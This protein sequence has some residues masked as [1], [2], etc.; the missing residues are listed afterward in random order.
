MSIQHYLINRFLKRFD[1]TSFDVF[2][3][4]GE[5]LH[6]GPEDSKFKMIMHKPLDYKAILTSTSLALGEAYMNGDFDIEGDLYVAIDEILHLKNQFSLDSKAL[7]KILY[8]S[9]S[10]KNQKN[11]VSS[12]YDIGNDFYK[13]WLDKTLSYSCAYFINEEDSLYE[14]QLNKVHYILAKLNLEEG[15]SL[16]DIGCGWGFLLIDHHALP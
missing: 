4:T 13:L 15:M 5:E 8:T 9:S 16:L 2:F 7:K 10:M 12:H 3:E 14:A 6:I 1:A 11:E